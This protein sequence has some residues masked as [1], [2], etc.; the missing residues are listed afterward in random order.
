[1]HALFSLSESGRGFVRIALLEQPDY[2]PG[3]PATMRSTPG[4]QG[5]LEDI[6]PDYGLQN[7]SG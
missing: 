2:W 5:G 7:M 4:E 1:M 3:R 6:Q